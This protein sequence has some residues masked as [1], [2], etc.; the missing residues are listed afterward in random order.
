[1]PTYRRDFLKGTVRNNLMRI[2]HISTFPPTR[3][4]IAEFANDLATNLVRVRSQKYRL[5]YSPAD[6]PGFAATII[7]TQRKNLADLG[8]KINTSEVEV[9]DLQHEFGIWGGDEGEN[10]IAFLGACRKPIVATLHTTFGP[11]NNP[12]QT[13]IIREICAAVRRVVVLSETAAYNLT[14]LEPTVKTKIAVIRHGVPDF[15][16]VGRDAL[17][18]EP[19]FVSPGFFRPDKGGEQVLRALAKAKSSG[20][21][22]NHIFA[23]GLQRQFA[24]QESYKVE[25]DAMTR[26]LGLQREVVIVEK[27]FDR[28]ELVGFVRDADC[29][30]IGYQNPIHGSS[31]MIPFILSAGRPV[32]S[33]PIEYSLQ[34]CRAVSGLI[35]VKGFSEDALFDGIQRFS[36][37]LSGWRKR[38][39]ELYAETRE[40]IWPTAAGQYRAVF[41]SAV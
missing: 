30:L 1:M 16:F 26:S 14:Q 34:A 9:V 10:I 19:V 13:R 31:G 22:F 4:G 5:V 28:D 41:Q 8:H 11:G 15:E 37:E 33:T 17:N 2:A 21:R 36:W 20:L 6:D 7:I 32:I 3:C 38:C 35:I 24:G 23:G 25:L 40:W 29:G 39:A 18:T 27:D 12:K